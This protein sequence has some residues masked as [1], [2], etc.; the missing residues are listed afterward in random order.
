MTTWNC[1]DRM[2]ETTWDYVSLGIVDDLKRIPG[3][4]SDL[5]PGPVVDDT[6]WTRVIVAGR[7]TGNGSGEPDIEISTA[8]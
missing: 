3:A 1:I 8:A 7:A 5:L 6:A 4:L 2:D